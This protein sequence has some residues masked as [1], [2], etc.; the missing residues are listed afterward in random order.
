MNFSRVLLLLFTLIF[1]TDRTLCNLIPAKNDGENKYIWLTYILISTY[2]IS[3]I[4]AFSEFIFFKKKLNLLFVFVG[5]ILL[6][7]GILLRKTSIKT[8][9]DNW[10]L[11]TR[12]S[13]N[14]KLIKFGPYKYIRHPYYLSVMLELIGFSLFLNAFYALYFIFIVHFPF[15]LLRI[16][17]EQK[18]LIS[19]FGKE[20]LNW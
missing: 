16:Y 11:H 20:Y 2:S 8:L 3:L 5:F 19:K 10:S 6:I 1:F 17:L 9:G 15:L 7:S 18:I 4:W 13:K 14:Q 12:D